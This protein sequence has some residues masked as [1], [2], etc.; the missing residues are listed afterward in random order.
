VI[1]E[2]AHAVIDPDQ[3]MPMEMLGQVTSS[4]YSPNVGASIAMAMLKG[5]HSMLGSKVYFP[6]L[7]GDVIEAEIVEPVFFDAKGERI[8]G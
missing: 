6:M 7:D 5:G 8:N 3:P 2:G 1:P 4:Y